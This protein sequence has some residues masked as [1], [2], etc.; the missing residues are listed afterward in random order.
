M[1]QT[2]AR[3]AYEPDREQHR[4]RLDEATREAQRLFKAHLGPIGGLTPA[5]LAVLLYYTLDPR[6]AGRFKADLDDARAILRATFPGNPMRDEPEAA[7]VLMQR[8]AEDRAERS[9]EGLLRSND[10]LDGLEDDLDFDDEA[11]ALTAIEGG[12]SE[13]DHVEALLELGWTADQIGVMSVQAR[14]ALASREIKAEDGAD[15]VDWTS[16]AM[17]VDLEAPADALPEP[18]KRLAAWLEDEGIVDLAM[19]DGES[20][21]A[22]LAKPGMGAATLKELR[23]VM[24]ARGLTLAE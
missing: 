4:M 15:F 17:L 5:G 23:A 9:I 7:L 21:G 12:V 2:D 20:A 1:P 8:L 14:A 6:M 24:E 3:A 13:G 10:D 18:S 11:P 16:G 19:L 22:L